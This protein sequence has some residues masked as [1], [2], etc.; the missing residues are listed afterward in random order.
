MALDAESVKLAETVDLTEESMTQTVNSK[1]EDGT[2]RKR[3]PSRTF[4]P[5]LRGTD[6]GLADSGRVQ[7]KKDREIQ[8]W[9]VLQNKGLVH[10]RIS[11]KILR[12]LLW[13][14]RRKAW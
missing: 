6:D 2:E 4:V 9:M 7:M 13:L 11:R 8:S 3:S 14:T 1:D 5:S 10:C 12:V